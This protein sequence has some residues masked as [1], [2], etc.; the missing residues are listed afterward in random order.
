MQAGK[1]YVGDLCYVMTDAEWDQFCKITI[2]GHRCLDGEFEMPDGRKFA[3][4]GTRYG[5]GLY[6][7]QFGN[8][9]GVDAGLIGCIRVEDIHPDKVDGI[10]CGAVHEFLTDFVTGGGRG[11]DRWHGTIQFG[12][13]LI[14]TG[15]D[16][17]TFDSYDDEQ[18]DCDD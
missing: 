16:A 1:Y 4:Y 5:D 14:E 8:R 15:D 7:D 12:R 3:S 9:Y 17:S 6:A 18:P 10:E 2:N 13:V 11:E